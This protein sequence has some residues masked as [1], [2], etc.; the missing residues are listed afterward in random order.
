[1]GPSPDHP[2]PEQP[3]DWFREPTRRE[4]WIAA[5]LFTGFGIFFV[6]LF[7]VLTGWWF[8]WIVLGL[9]MYS[10]LHGLGHARDA[11]HAKRVD[12]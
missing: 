5:G 11:R 9:G 8:R 10:V 3:T 7:V 6:A 12:E 1:M 4:H 2:A